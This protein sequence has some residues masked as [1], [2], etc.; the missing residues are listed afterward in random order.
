MQRAETAAAGRSVASAS[1]VVHQDPQS[2]S[3]VAADTTPVTNSEVWG[4]H[5]NKPTEMLGCEYTDMP[6]SI[7][8]EE[9]SLQRLRGSPY[10]RRKP[11]GGISNQ[12]TRSYEYLVPGLNRWHE[13]GGEPLSYINQKVNHFPYGTLRR[14]ERETTVSAPDVNIPVSSG[15]YEQWNMI[16]LTGKGSSYGPR[17]PAVVHKPAIGGSRDGLSYVCHN[18]FWKNAFPG[19][20]MKLV[21]S[22]PDVSLKEPVRAP[23][24]NTLQSLATIGNAPEKTASSP[25]VHRPAPVANGWIASSPTGYPPRMLGS[26][27]DINLARVHSTGKKLNESAAGPNQNVGCNEPGMATCRGHEKNLQLMQK[28]EFPLDVLHQKC[29]NSAPDVRIPTAS[30]WVERSAKYDS[31]PSLCTHDDQSLYKKPEC[32]LCFSHRAPVGEFKHHIANR[33]AVHHHHTLP[34]QQQVDEATHCHCNNLSWRS[35]ATRRHYYQH[36]DVV[37]TDFG[38]TT[39]GHHS[40]THYSH[41]TTVHGGTPSRMGDNFCHHV[42]CGTCRPH[43]NH[44][45]DPHRSHYQHHHDHC[46]HEHKQKCLPNHHSH[47]DVRY[48]HGCPNLHTHLPQE[49]QRSITESSQQVCFCYERG[50]HS[51]LQRSRHTCCTSPDFQE[52]SHGDCHCCRHH[53]R[54]RYVSRDGGLSNEVRSAMV[55]DCYNSGMRAVSAMPFDSGESCEAMGSPVPHISEWGKCERQDAAACLG[56][57]S[58]GALREAR[59]HAPRQHADPLQGPA[60]RRWDDGLPVPAAT[61][62]LRTPAPPGRCSPAPGTA[63]ARSRPEKPRT[64]GVARC[65]RASRRRGPQTPKSRPPP[66]PPPGA[67]GRGRRRSRGRSPVRCP[68]APHVASAAQT[69]R[70]VWTRRPLLL[71]FR[72]QWKHAHIHHLPSSTSQTRQ[73]PDAISRRHCATWNSTRRKGGI[74]GMRTPKFPFHLPLTTGVTI[75]DSAPK[76][77]RQLVTTASTLCHRGLLPWT[78]SRNRLSPD[79]TAASASKRGRNATS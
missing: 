72:H 46:H 39:H 5:N 43:C 52:V 73:L 66:S 55:D 75:V 35:L 18:E 31:H 3:S 22:A 1:S 56:M 65:R 2:S 28:Q 14:D 17:P 20:A 10:I 40:T 45:H 8:N 37:T 53:A 16:G 51:H 79:W 30:P 76:M 47:V 74:T 49:H 63:G 7:S 6:A 13:T 26:A 61:G 33:H 70:W 12:Q 64:R 58:P 57:P 36:N 42:N 21:A 15:R 24:W 9:G 48:K 4:Q 59:G 54:N 41:V 38:T 62:G 77:S 27:P 50:A 23:A 60:Q 19:V 67:D 32:S 68:S 44:E 34:R 11:V 25:D 71:T 78:A 29:G 69:R